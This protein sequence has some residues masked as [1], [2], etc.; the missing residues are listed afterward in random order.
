[1]LTHSGIAATLDCLQ[2]FMLRCTQGSEQILCS[3]PLFTFFLHRLVRLHGIWDTPRNRKA[4]MLCDI[5]PCARKPT[6]F[7]RNVRFCVW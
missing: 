1:M 4:V 3:L 2:V 5:L 6:F 7:I